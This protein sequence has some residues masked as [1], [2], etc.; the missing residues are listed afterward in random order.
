MEIVMVSGPF[1]MRVLDD[2]RTA[3]TDPRLPAN[4]PRRRLRT[5]G[6]GLRRSGGRRWVTAGCRRRYQRVDRWQGIL[7][8]YSVYFDFFDFFD[9]FDLFTFWCVSA[10]ITLYIATSI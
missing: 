2:V 1:N 5:A 4:E 9:F 10:L 3:R 8:H 6:T 7:Y